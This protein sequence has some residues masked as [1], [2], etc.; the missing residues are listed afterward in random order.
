MAALSLVP[1][2]EL[3]AVNYMLATLGEQ[4]VNSL[5]VVGNA[6]VQM[7]QKFL[8]QV[9]RQVQAKGMSFNTD[10][11]YPLSLD[12]DGKIPLPTNTLYVKASDPDTNK[13]TQRGLFLYDI[14]NH[15]FIF[16][17]AV[18]VTIACFLAFEDLPQSVRDY[19]TISAARRFQIAVLGSDTLASLSAYDEQQALNNMQA[20]ELEASHN[21]IFDQEDV[22]RII[23]R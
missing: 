1:I 11:D 7:A 15:T 14:E 21:N 19:I 23:R 4:P 3:D 13:I 20:L 6:E 17:E 16:T 8:H 12:G 18:D 22:A 5:D 2:T 9:N 10:Y